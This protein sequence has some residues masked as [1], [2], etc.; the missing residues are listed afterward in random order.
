MYL[1]L[2]QPIEEICYYNVAIVS[3]LCKFQL[4][5]IHV[6]FFKC[7]SRREL[8]PKEISIPSV[9]VW[10]RGGVGEHGYFLELHIVCKVEA[11]SFKFA[12]HVSDDQ[13]P[14]S[15]ANTNEPLVGVI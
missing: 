5:F 12:M 4:S 8:P 10:G 15:V 6:H 2:S 11:H 3:P 7:F 9:C 13:H 1:Y 14:L